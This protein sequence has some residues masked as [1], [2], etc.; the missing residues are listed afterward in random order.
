MRLLDTFDRI[1]VINLPERTD[2]RR[3]MDAELAAVGL[4]GDPRVAYFPGI[5]P[6]DQGRFNS[7]GAHGVYLG[8]AQILREAVAAG[9]S[10]LILE[11]DCA[12]SSHAAEFEAK[13]AWDIFYGGHDAANP[14]DLHN[15]D[16]IGAHMMGFSREG[17]VQVS[18]YL[19][20]LDPD[21][22]V[23]PPIDAAYIWFRRAHPMVRTEFAVPPLAVQRTSRSDIARSKWHHRLPGGR[24]L[25]GW[26][27]RTLQAKTDR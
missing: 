25:G 16:I 3:E 17:A 14:H 23:H 8:Q 13:T 18:A 27:R 22:A 5:R 20:A 26:V 9:A 6:A 19:D 2:R 7:I 12:F 21:D 1:R 24:Q 4:A 15:S 11:D 10:V